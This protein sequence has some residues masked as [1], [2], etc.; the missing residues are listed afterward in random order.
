MGF[1]SKIVRSVTKPIKKVIKSPIGKAALIGGLGYLATPGTGANFWSP[2]GKGAWWKGLGPR[3]FGGGAL[4]PSQGLGQS[5]GILGS[6][7]GWAKNNPELAIGAGVGLGTAAMAAGQPKVDEIEGFGGGDEGK[8]HQAYL[9]M[10]KQF[11]FG[12]PDSEYYTEPMWKGNQG[13]RVPAAIGMSVDQESVTRDPG[14]DET[15]ETQTDL[16]TVNQPTEEG[17]LDTGTTEQ[18]ADSQL[19]Q[20]IQQLSAMGIPMEQLRG[21]TME[22]LVEMMVYVSAKMQG[23]VQED[24]MSE[25][26]TMAQGGR[27]GLY[28]GGNELPEDPTKPI[29]PF[30]PKPIGPVLPD[31]QMASANN[32]M[33]EKNDMALEMFGKELRLLTEEEMEILDEEIQRLRSKFM[34]KG[35]R[36]GYRFG[37]EVQESTSPSDIFITDSTEILRGKPD[38]SEGGITNTNAAMGLEHPVIPSQDGNQLDMREAGGYQPHGAQEKKDD[39]RALL[40]QGEFVV[41]SDAVKGVG[42]GDR[43]LGAKRMYDM[44]HKWEA[45]A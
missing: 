17:I 12:D 11:G 28:G 6:A 30:A 24:V 39:V 9:N 29:N 8:G 15:L 27:I 14:L 19:I 36:A 4:P 40:A 13:G 20:L 1:F 10:R 21:R 31:K 2:Q 23:G 32:P 35:G 25:Q 44:M 42:G 43:D 26:V 5:Q 7:L 16:S 18:S 37:D 3:I 45:M 34:A 38:G 33:A 41:T 22:E